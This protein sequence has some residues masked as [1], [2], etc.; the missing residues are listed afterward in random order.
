LPAPAPDAVNF[1]RSPAF[2]DLLNRTNHLADLL[3]RLR[4]FDPDGGAVV[5]TDWRSQAD[6]PLMPFL[7]S[8]Q[9]PT[10]LETNRMAMSSLRNRG[11]LLRSASQAG[12]ETNRTELASAFLDAVE[13]DRSRLEELA[14]AAATATVFQV[15]TNSDIGAVLRPDP[16]PILLLEHLHLLFQVRASAE[17]ASGRNAEAAEDVLTGLRLAQL[18]R[19]LPDT[20]LMARVQWLLAHSL[21]PLWEGLYQQAWTQPQLAAF[22]SQLA[23]FNLLTDYTNAVRRVVLAHIELWHAIPGSTNIQ[24]ALAA[25]NAT[26]YFA[27][28][29][30]QLQPSAWWFDNCIRLYGAGQNAI[31]RVDLEA[32]R[33]GEDS[34]QLDLNGLPLDA[35]THEL[36]EQWLWVQTPALLAFAQTS[37][38]QALVACAL[39]R[40]RLA[41]GAYPASLQP[42][43]P[44]LLAGIPHD[45]VSGRPIIYQADGGTNFILRGVG[46]NG[47]DDRKSA[48][49]DDWLWTYGTNAPNTILGKPG[50]SGQPTSH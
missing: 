17:L 27:Q 42:L 14:A 2:A 26:A 34:S 40:F 28:P 49:S 19:Q 11:R 1:A 48:V 41:N 15:I 7:T 9:Q 5:L 6:A 33:I 37:V 29:E 3:N 46:P 8:V 18:A 39:E 50:L 35:A 16:Q 24:A 47:V 30:W 31:Q 13:P 38:N 20:R 22:Q 21:Q 4:D 10:E 23:G 12:A 43:V 32:G 36:L 25:A 45:A 44:S